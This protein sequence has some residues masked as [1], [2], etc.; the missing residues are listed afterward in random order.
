MRKLLLVSLFLLAGCH[1]H[2]SHRDSL[3]DIAYGGCKYGAT[4]AEIYYVENYQMSVMGEHAPNKIC[5]DYIEDLK[6]LEQERN[7]E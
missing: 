3:Y 2:K 6:K 1:K 4:T 7:N 5:E